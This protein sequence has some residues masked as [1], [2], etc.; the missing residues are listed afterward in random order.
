[1]EN[2]KSIAYAV[3]FILHIFKDNRL[4]TSEESASIQLKVM[5]IK[6][7][8]L[9]SD[10]T[11]IS[12][13]YVASPDHY[14]S[15]IGPRED[16]RT[17]HGGI[18]T[19][20]MPGSEVYTASVNVV[21]LTSLRSIY[22]RLFNEEQ[23]IS[24]QI[25][26]IAV[27]TPQEQDVKQPHSK[28]LEMDTIFMGPNTSDLTITGVI[29]FNVSFMHRFSPI[30]VYFEGL[31]TSADPPTFFE[32]FDFDFDNNSEI[33]VS[34]SQRSNKT[35]N[36]HIKLDR[37]IVKYGGFL[38]ILVPYKESSKDRMVDKYSRGTTVKIYPYGT[39]DILPYNE[40]GTIPLKNQ[41]VIF[42]PSSRIK[43]LAI[44]NPRPTASI[45]KKVDNGGY[46]KLAT[47][48]SYLDRYSNLEVLSLSS[49]K[50]THE[51]RYICRASNG[52]KTV[53][54]ETDVVMLTKAIIDESMTGVLEN[55]ST[56]IIVSCKATGKPRPELEF[57]LYDE[58]G[59]FMIRSGLFK[60]LESKTGDYASQITLTLSAV[61]DVDIHTVYCYAAQGDKNRS[62]EISKKINIF[63]EGRDVN[64][65]L[66]NQIREN[67]MFQ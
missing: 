45:F 50:Q 6:S 58:Y 40:V 67:E 52:D 61:E 55:S 38:T 22:F 47:E 24:L 66:Y 64:W 41:T 31:N 49:N 11:K 56:T 27:E 43:C 37:N 23:T 51:G 60:T 5:S 19:Q 32:K 1:M 14:V 10:V 63:P 36:C 54:S 28:L 29:N 2:F 16:G 46:K 65:N 3:V 35:T 48:T 8:G 62:F 30:E 18:K 9:S 7:S 39:K 57:R 17:W 4:F 33:S 12:I 53:E 20:T 21:N 13:T 26:T 25:N 44:G 59:P 15:W 34:F 42:P